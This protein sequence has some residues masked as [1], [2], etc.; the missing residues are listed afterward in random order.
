MASVPFPPLALVPYLTQIAAIL[1]E[2]KQSVCVAETAAGGLISA[3]L[4]SVPGASAYYAGGLT[5]YTLASRTTFCD[6]TP[7]DFVN[8]QGPTPAIVERLATSTRAK[9]QATYAI[10]E[11]GTAGPTTA[12]P[13]QTLGYVA[14]AIA[15]PSGVISRELKTGTSDRQTNMVL[16][17]EEA[18]KFFLQVL[19]GEIAERK[20]A[21]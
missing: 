10:S 13:T 16:F 14:L 6:F 20:M 12:R 7:D 15:T 5:V 2:R 21:L 17:A 18:L 3:S 9:L 11:S 19:K 8:Y 1:T 4:L